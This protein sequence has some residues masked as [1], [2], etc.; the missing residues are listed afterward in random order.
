MNLA[1]EK[2]LAE[3]GFELWEAGREAQMLPLCYEAPLPCRVSQDD[4]VKTTK[5]PVK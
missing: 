4:R 3:Q 5:S 2:I 1:V